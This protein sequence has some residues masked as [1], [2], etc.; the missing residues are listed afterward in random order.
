MK[1]GMLLDMHFYAS[2]LNDSEK[3][4]WLNFCIRINSRSVCTD[5]CFLYMIFFLF[6]VRISLCVL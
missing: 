3:K 2:F 6:G 5:A 1:N 4:N